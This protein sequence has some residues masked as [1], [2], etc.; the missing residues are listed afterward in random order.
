MRTWLLQRMVTD[1]GRV[2]GLA[3]VTWSWW[4]IVCGPLFVA[5]ALL[6]PTS[7]RPVL[8][9]QP[10]RRIYFVYPLPACTSIRTPAVTWINPSDEH[11]TANIYEYS[12]WWSQP[13][14]H[15]TNAPVVQNTNIPPPAW[16]AQG[17]NSHIGSRLGQ[18]VVCCLMSLPISFTFCRSQ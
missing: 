10:L 9:V 2:I 13:T 8:S 15:C 11:C 1:R 7:C 17:F 12:L 3:C 16:A 6:C 5:M 14:A 4:I 18:N